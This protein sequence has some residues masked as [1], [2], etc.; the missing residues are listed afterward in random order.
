MTG[1]A[2]SRG[3]PTRLGLKGDLAD[4]AQ[5]SLIAVDAPPRGILHRLPPPYLKFLVR[6]PAEAIHSSV[7]T[8]IQTCTGNS[9]SNLSWESSLVEPQ[10]NEA[11]WQGRQ[12]KHQAYAG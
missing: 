3:L 7:D 9:S 6:S 4:R 12:Q 8:A 5:P 2:V 11:L 10:G 1:A